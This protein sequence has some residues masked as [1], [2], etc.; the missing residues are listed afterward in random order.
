MLGLEQRARPAAPLV[1]A[2]SGLLAPFARVLTSSW[3]RKVLAVTFIEGALAFGALA[4]VPA[5][6]HLRFGLSMAAAG[7]VM[8]VYGVG[9][10][11]YSRGARRLV[12]RLGEIKLAAL[13]GTSLALALAALA[14][15]SQWQWAIAACALAG[16]GFYA[17]HST[18]QTHATQMAPEARGTAVSL[19]ACSLFIGQSSGVVAAAWAMDRFSATLLFASASTGLFFLAWTFVWLLRRHGRG[20]LLR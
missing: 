8:A 13:G 17:L 16:S 3:A 18:L 2:R 15:V 7:A 1:P 12:R 4:F 11:A 6:L 5:Y 19:F 20:P 9:G 14:L 10:L